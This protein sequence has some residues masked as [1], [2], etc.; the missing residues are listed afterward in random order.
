MQLEFKKKKSSAA[1]KSQRPEQ[2][3]TS[4]RAGQ[5]KLETVHV[6]LCSEEASVAID[7]GGGEKKP[8]Y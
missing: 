2:R 1:K 6:N 7:D 8:R 5:R 4:R 3:E